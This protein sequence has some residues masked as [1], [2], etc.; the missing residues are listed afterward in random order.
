LLGVPPASETDETIG[1]LVFDL[2]GRT[3]E[4]G[5]GVEADER[6]LEVTG[7]DGEAADDDAER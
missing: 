1:G 6:V 5:D 2:L 7:V 4:A 3:P